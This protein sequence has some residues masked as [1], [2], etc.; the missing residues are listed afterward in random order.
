MTTAPTTTTRKTRAR[1]GGDGLRRRAASRSTSRGGG[2]RRRGD[3]EDKGKAHTNTRGRGEGGK[4]VDD[5]ATVRASGSEWR[6]RDDGTRASGAPKRFLKPEQVDEYLTLRRE[7]ESERMSDKKHGIIDDIFAF[8]KREHRH[9]SRVAGVSSQNLN[10]VVNARRLALT[11]YIIFSLVLENFLMLRGVQVESTGSNEPVKWQR[12]SDADDP[13]LFVR[14]LY[15]RYVPLAIFIDVVVLAQFVCVDAG[16]RQIAWLEDVGFIL[17]HLLKSI[18][19]HPA[20]TLRIVGY[21]HP[22]HTFGAKQIVVLLAGP[23]FVMNRLKLFENFTSQVI[24]SLINFIIY[25]IYSVLLSDTLPVYTSYGR[26]HVSLKG[27]AVVTFMSPACWV[28]AA[29][30]EY[31]FNGSERGRRTLFR[32]H[33]LDGFSLNRSWAARLLCGEDSSR[34]RCTNQINLSCEQIA[35]AFETTEAALMTDLHGAR[36]RISAENPSTGSTNSVL[37]L[38]WRV[39]GRR[40]TSYQ[41]SLLRNAAT[42]Y[43]VNVLRIFKHK[44]KVYIDLDSEEIWAWTTSRDAHKDSASRLRRVYDGLGAFNDAGQVATKVQ[45]Q[46]DTP[47]LVEYFARVNGPLKVIQTRERA[48]SPHKSAVCYSNMIAIVTGSVNSIHLYGRGFHRSRVYVRVGSSSFPVESSSARKMRHLD[49]ITPHIE[50]ALSDTA[51][52]RDAAS[53]SI[54]QEPLEH[55]SFILDTSSCSVDCVG[56]LVIQIIGEC[57]SFGFPIIATNDLDVKNELNDRFSC[58]HL[59]DSTTLFL[60]AVGRALAHSASPSTTRFLSHVAFDND[61]PRLGATL[62]DMADAHLYTTVAF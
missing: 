18:M 6:T 23:T 21:T 19:R 14:G 32:A 56:H 46:V 57:M 55:T 48:A 52:T 15:T 58:V 16:G 43:S 26:S 42:C 12:L 24:V 38:I 10:H 47:L 3:A 62:R 50:Y 54:D 45:L 35:S 44:P 39:L 28:F 22:G 37:S 25:P 9:V 5:R 20:M 11:A 29:A 59:S 60:H 2:A 8:F 51:I 30:K 27:W 31:V 61:L 1:S 41:H 17:R 7:S 36:I 33:A 4:D 49:I 13:K 40:K 34:A 53:S